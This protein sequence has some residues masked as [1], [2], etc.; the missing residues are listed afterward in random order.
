M[1]FIRYLTRLCDQIRVL[2]SPEHESRLVFSNADLTQDSDDDDD[3]FAFG[4]KASAEPMEEDGD[5]G[6]DRVFKFEVAKTNEQE[7]DAKIN[8]AFTVSSR[9]SLMGTL[10]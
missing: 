6:E 1:T 4:M 3:D 7:E 10:L 5:E 8:P 2:I 9:N